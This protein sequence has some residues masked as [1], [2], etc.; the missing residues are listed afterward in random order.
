MSS[1]KATKVRATEV[2]DTLDSTGRQR[3][4]KRDEVSEKVYHQHIL[5]PAN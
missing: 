1:K 5:V 3:Q 4:L 2:V